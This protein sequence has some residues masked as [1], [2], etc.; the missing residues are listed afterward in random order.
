MMGLNIRTSIFLIFTFLL[1]GSCSDRPKKPVDFGF[2]ITLGTEIIDS[3]DST[4]KRSYI[5]YDTTVR[6]VFT[7]SEMDSIYDAVINNGLD[8]YPD[9]FSPDCKVLSMPRFRTTLILKIEEK[10][11]IFVI[12]DDC[13]QDFLKFW[14][15]VKIKKVEQ[16]VSIIRNVVHAKNE[17]KKLPDTDIRFM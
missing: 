4:F 5:D 2:K 9:S 7:A 16:V 17:I 13:T 6:L 8:N 10:K 3:F 1:F 12:S 14:R 11:K 15:N